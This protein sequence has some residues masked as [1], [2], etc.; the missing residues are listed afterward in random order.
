MAQ[1]Q[2]NT[3][4]DGNEPENESDD[5]P[6]LPDAWQWGLGEGGSGHYTRPFHTKA[7]LYSDGEFG[8][9][10]EIYWDEGQGH[11]VTFRQIRKKLPNEDPVYGYEQHT[12]TFDTEEE[13]LEYACEKAAEL[14]S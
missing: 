9:D 5:E 14:R 2:P 8:W 4:G 7:W 1:S 12:Q 6:E 3:N 11:T 13:A 10:G